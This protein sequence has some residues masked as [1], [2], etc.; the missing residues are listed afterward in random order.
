MRSTD[1]EGRTRL[2]GYINEKCEL[3]VSRKEAPERVLNVTA[4]SGDLLL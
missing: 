1:S 4:K 2:Q 3:F